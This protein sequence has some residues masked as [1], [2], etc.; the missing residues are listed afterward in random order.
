MF[1]FTPHT[2]LRPDFVRAVPSIGMTLAG[3]RVNYKW[4]ESK[5]MSKYIRF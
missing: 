1:P 5:F 4:S 2:T 3:G